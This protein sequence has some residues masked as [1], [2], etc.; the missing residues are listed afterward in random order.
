M[1]W[2]CA[3]R[4]LLLI[5]MPIMS[6]LWICWWNHLPNWLYGLSN[7]MQIHFELY[8]LIPSQESGRGRTSVKTKLNLRLNKSVKSWSVCLYLAANVWTVCLLRMYYAWHWRFHLSV[9]F[10]YLFIFLDHSVCRQRSSAMII[11]PLS[12]T[13]HMGQKN[14]GTSG[15][16]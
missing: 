7:H 15:R 13:C 16:R 14:T 3:W 10:I 6:C 4:V 1:R 11:S 9:L 12:G 8:P 5:M 2:R